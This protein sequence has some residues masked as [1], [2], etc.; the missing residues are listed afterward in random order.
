MSIP[1]FSDK[2]YSETEVTQRLGISLERLHQLL[3][4][5]VFTTGGPRPEACVFRHSDLLLLRYWNQNESGLMLVP[6]R[7]K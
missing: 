7:K 1:L 3:D 2:T 5:H 4:E 6:A